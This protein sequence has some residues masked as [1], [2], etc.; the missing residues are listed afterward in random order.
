MKEKTNAA[1]TKQ[2]LR[3]ELARRKNA[4]RALDQQRA[5]AVRELQRIEAERHCHVKR[6]FGTLTR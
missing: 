5:A 6:L 3:D 1:E 2:A 4:V